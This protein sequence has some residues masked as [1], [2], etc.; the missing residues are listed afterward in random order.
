MLHFVTFKPQPPTN[1]PH[2]IP[3]Q[4]A[5]IQGKKGPIALSK[6]SVLCPVRQMIFIKLKPIDSNGLL[7]P[8]QIT[9]NIPDNLLSVGF[10]QIYVVIRYAPTETFVQ[11]LG[12]AYH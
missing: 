8:P 6:V 7:N 1:H 12:S 4:S 5:K 9:S 10:K 2:L 11:A 3:A